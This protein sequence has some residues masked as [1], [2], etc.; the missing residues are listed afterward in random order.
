LLVIALLLGATDALMF[1][2]GAQWAPR[3]EA[4][5][6]K[7]A[8]RFLAALSRNVDAWYADQI[9]YAT[10]GERQRETWDAIHAAGPG[11]EELVLRCL[12]EQL[13]PVAG[14]SR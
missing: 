1:S 11:I 12:R 13:P 8:K 7:T 5:M 6:T 2:D 14:G 4:Q 10:F 3:T 9:D